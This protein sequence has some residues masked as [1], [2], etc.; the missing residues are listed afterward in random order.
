MWVGETELPLGHSGQ[1]L[2]SAADSRS[3]RWAVTA[4]VEG[5]GGLAV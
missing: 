4:A 5:K 1:K 3:A 2:F